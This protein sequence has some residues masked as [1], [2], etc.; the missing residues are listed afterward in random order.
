VDGTLLS[1][2]T[3]ITG[4]IKS[5]WSTVPALIDSTLILA[6]FF[7]NSKDPQLAQNRF[8]IVLPLSEV[9]VKEETSPE[10]STSSSGT[11]RFVPKTEPV[12][13]RQS[14]Q[15]QLNIALGLA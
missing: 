1:I 8:V 3:F 10:I 2:N 13:R 12:A 15:W 4:L 11:K 7:P 5:N 6:L 9:W 14:S